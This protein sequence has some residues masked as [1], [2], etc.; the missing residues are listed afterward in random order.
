MLPEGCPNLRN[1]DLSDPLKVRYG[2]VT[3]FGVIGLAEG[4]PE[5]VRLDL[6]CSIITDMSIIRLSESCPNLQSLHLNDAVLLM[7]A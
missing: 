5:L 7:E 3:D 6:Q 1:L 2:K 4:Y